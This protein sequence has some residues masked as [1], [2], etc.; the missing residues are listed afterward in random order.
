M[1]VVSSL[2]RIPPVNCQIS[3]AIE[4]PNGVDLSKL[5]PF[6]RNLIS[7]P[8][9]EGHYRFRRF[10]QFEVIDRQIHQLPHRQFL[11]SKNYNPLLG[12]VGCRTGI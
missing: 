5:R 7:D 2:N 9:L 1:S 12:D 10:S 8:Y 3:Y 11:Q 6:F 4:H